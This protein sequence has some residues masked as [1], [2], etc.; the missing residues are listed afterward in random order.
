M[1]GITPPPVPAKFGQKGVN[2]PLKCVLG[3]F[4]R[5]VSP[6]RLP[7]G[8]PPRGFR[9]LWRPD[10][11]IKRAM[12]MKASLTLLYRGNRLKTSPNHEFSLLVRAWVCGISSLTLA[13]FLTHFFPSFS[14]LFYSTFVWLTPACCSCRQVIHLSS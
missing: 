13:H 3:L 6:W 8:V 12:Q 4:E 7:P 14:S 11:Q 5:G 1:G 9:V 2:R 10:R